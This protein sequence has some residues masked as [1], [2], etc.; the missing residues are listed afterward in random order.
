[1]TRT[2]AALL[3]VACTW[4]LG[5]D[6]AHAS[7]AGPIEPVRLA[8]Y[9]LVFAGEVLDVD[10]GG[11]VAEVRVVDVWRGRDLP[12]EVVVF[13]GPPESAG[14]SS[15]DR[16]FE[17]GQTYAFFAYEDEDGVLRDNACTATARLRERAALDP[18]GVRA[19]RADAPAPADPRTP[20]WMWAAGGAATVGAAAV[21]VALRRR[22]RSA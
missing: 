11:R 4:L 9:E 13:G 8:E 22:R 14:F 2:R 18:P 3:A 6:A 1:M 17:G 10:D 5:A 19:P 16:V 12:P 21:A 20:P 15:V 7:C